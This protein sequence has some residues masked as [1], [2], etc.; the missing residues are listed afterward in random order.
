M[1]GERDLLQETIDLLK[2]IDKAIGTVVS[3]GVTSGTFNRHITPLTSEIKGMITELQEMQ[4][5]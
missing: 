1:C 2:T 5:D 3:N 4:E